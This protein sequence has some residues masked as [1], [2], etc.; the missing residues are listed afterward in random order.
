MTGRAGSQPESFLAGPE[1]H[2]FGMRLQHAMDG[3]A[4][5]GLA[6][7][8]RCR[9]GAQP[10]MPTPPPP[11]LLRLPSGALEVTYDRLLTLMTA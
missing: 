4:V 9:G 8:W 10:F 2:A 11:P 3:L 7:A 5:R 1:P 6:S